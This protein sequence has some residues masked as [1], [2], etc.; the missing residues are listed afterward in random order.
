MD[1][2]PLCP[3]DAVSAVMIVWRIRGNLEQLPE[4]LS[5]ECCTKI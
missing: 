2:L 5:H 3:V 1:E 4:L